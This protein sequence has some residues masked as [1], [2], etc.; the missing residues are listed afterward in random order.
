MYTALK[1]VYKDIIY[2]IL[3]I[4][5][6]YLFIKV[7]AIHLLQWDSFHRRILR[8]A[9]VM[10]ALNFEFESIPHVSSSIN[11]DSKVRTHA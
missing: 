1:S 8:S 2:F 5:K 6:Y 11:H 7:L 9:E 3:S 10:A 4:I